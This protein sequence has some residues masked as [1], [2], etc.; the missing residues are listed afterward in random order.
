MK[1]NKIGEFVSANNGY[2]ISAEAKTKDLV[3]IFNEN[4]IQSIV[5]LDGSKTAGLVMRDKLFYRLGSRFGYNL[6]MQKNIKEIMD[7]KPLLVD[8]EQS[9]FEVS[10]LA[11]IRPQAD[12]YDSIIINKN[13]NY[14]STLSIKDLLIEVAEIKVEQA[15]NANPLTGLPGNHSIEIELKELIKEEKIFSVLYIDL[16]NFK[17]YNDSY[18]YQKGD[19]VIQF[20][21]EVLCNTVTELNV[22]SFIGHV[23]GDDFV[24]ITETC[25]DTIIAEIIIENF[26]RGIKRYLKK[27]DLKNG[28]FLCCN[29]SHKLS[30]IPLTSISI[31]IISNEFLQ[32]NSH[33]EV[34]DRAAELKKK[35]KEKAGSNYFKNRRKDSANVKDE[36]CKKLK[37]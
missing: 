11:M 12:V 37:L 24:L 34:S 15:R 1:I 2:T 17:A 6:Y 21:A 9:I 20:T 26:D 36:L 27:S 25:F 7:A 33:L 18:G 3:N 4:N 13:G 19:E 16:D 30:K 23:G 14:Y 35:V 29:R 32:I 22:D 31:A 5:V 10:K 28:F 8:Y